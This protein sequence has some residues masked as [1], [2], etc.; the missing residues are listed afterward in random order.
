LKRK[1]KI[2][3][4]MNAPMHSGKISL[5]IPVYNEGRIIEKH[6]MKIHGVMKALGE[7]FEIIIV[8]DNSSD[9]TES[10][11]KN[12]VKKNKDIRYI[13][14]DN[15]PSRRENL[16][17]SFGKA[18]GSIVAF[19]DADLAVDTMYIRQLFDEVKKGADIVIGSRYAKGSYVKRTIL[20]LLVSTFYNMFIKMY[21][22]SKVLD[23]QCGFKA[24]RK[25]VAQDIVKGMGY[26]K[27]FQRGWFWDAEFL[28]RAQKKKY[29]IV[30]FPVLWKHGQ[31]SEFQFKRE[32]RLIP[33]MIRLKRELK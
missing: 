31:K 7:P 11:C 12:L 21:F 28:I 1:V 5:F 20:R 26:D 10:E 27:K 24:F 4:W 32:L 3:G 8:D 14:Y 33:Y 17:A 29:K 30:E 9:N 6:I 19:M 22:G 2:V 25:E 16:S 18:R 15:G 13:R 23:H